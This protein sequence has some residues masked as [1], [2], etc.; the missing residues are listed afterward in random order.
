MRKSAAILA[1]ALGL[2]LLSS[3]THRARKALA[4]YEGEFESATRYVDMGVELRVVRR[5]PDSTYRLPDPDLPPVTVV[6]TIRRGGMADTARDPVSLCGPSANP[7]IWHCSE[8]AAEIIVHASNIPDRLLAIGSMGASKTVTLCQWLYFRALEY[9]G[10]NVEFGAV[11]PTNP[12]LDFIAKGI[13]QLY[14]TT[15]WRWK[16]RTQVFSLANTVDIRLVSA[17]RS[18]Q[19][20]GSRLQG[21]TW[22]VI[23]V[24]ELQDLIEENDNIEARG[25]GPWS[26]QRLNTATAKDDPHWRSFRDRLKTIA[27]WAERTMFGPDSPF[28]SPSY[29]EDLKATMS[30]RAYQSAILAMDVAPENRTYPTWER[31][32]NLR[33]VPVIGAR[34]VTASELARIGYAGASILAG[35]DPGKTCR[36]T[37]LLK[38][39]QF[40]SN[41]EPEWFVV[42]EITSD[43]ATTEAHGLALIDYVKKRWGD[44]SQLLVHIDPHSNGSENDNEHPDFTVKTTL[45]NL[46]LNVREAAYMPGKT[47][48]GRIGRKARV[49]MVNTLLCS[50][51]MVKDARG[52]LVLDAQDNPINVRRLYVACDDRRQPVAPKLVE[53]FERL[54]NDA[55]GNPDRG[56]KGAGDFTHWP[57]ALGYA[58]WKIEKPRLDA[59]RR[60]A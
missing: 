5:D 15:W 2:V 52:N 58:L 26:L 30:P 6:Q 53:A 18:S 8:A 29:W 55:D 45:K 12:R 56:K 11:A 19:A 46:G 35:H 48:P 39:Y 32:H 21:Y 33:P 20:E 13:R 7:V 57:A 44:P 27:Q 3:L 60:T 34:D 59:G 1:L 47:T 31:K 42:G 28:V 51:R 14:P 24:D 23:G 25:R 50:A 22:P 37:E 4:E 49:E 9:T 43:R 40:G 54:E 16:E 17:H 10:A 38:A 36:V 41:P